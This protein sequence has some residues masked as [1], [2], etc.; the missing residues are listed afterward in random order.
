[1]IRITFGRASRSG[2]KRQSNRRAQRKQRT[3][4]IVLPLARSHALRNRF[5]SLVLNP[6]VVAVL[7]FISLARFLCC[8][9]FLLFQ[10]PL[11]FDGTLCAT[12]SVCRWRPQ[13]CDD[14]LAPLPHYYF[15]RAR[16]GLGRG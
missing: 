3:R 15:G 11:K 6:A 5:P 14:W 12:F 8:L 10:P 4:R 7:Q 2:G 13:P 9:C 1:M 16:A